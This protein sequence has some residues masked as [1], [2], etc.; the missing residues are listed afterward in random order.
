MKLFLNAFPELLFDGIHALNNLRMPLVVML[1]FD[2][3]GESQVAGL[4][5][6]RS[7]NA[8]S[9]QKFFA[10]FKVD[11]PKHDQIKVIMSDKSCDN[12]NAFQAAFPNAEHQLC[13][14][15]VH[16]I[17]DREV[18]TQKRNLTIQQRADAIRIL[19][20][21]VYATSQTD[22]DNLYQSL[23][24][25]RSPELMSYF[26]DNWN[27]ITEKWV[28]FKVNQHVI[29]ENRTNNRLESS[30]KKLNQLCPNIRR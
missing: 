1:V 13:I 9:F 24:N 28:G 19:R 3:N 4:A 2:G 21:M 7:E 20:R 26:N 14:F 29:Y 12:R 17:F 6:V 10:E 5:V 27:N 25:I 11:N 23:R 16:R 15:H 8:D 18:T 30:T 22:Y